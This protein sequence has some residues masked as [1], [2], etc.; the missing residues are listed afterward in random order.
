MDVHVLTPRG[1]ELV[2]QVLD[3]RVIVPS[4]PPVAPASALAPPA[5]CK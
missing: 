4:A 5:P 1:A 2:V 3:G